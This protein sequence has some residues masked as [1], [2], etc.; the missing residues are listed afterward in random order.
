MFYSP[1]QGLARIEAFFQVPMTVE[2]LYEYLSAKI[3]SCL[4]RLCEG[5][6]QTLRKD[7]C[8]ERLCALLHGLFI[9]VLSP[10]F[11]GGGGSDLDP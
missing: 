7:D 10:L 9:L 2:A 3:N 5:I 8:C 1:K 6:G 4:K 11:K